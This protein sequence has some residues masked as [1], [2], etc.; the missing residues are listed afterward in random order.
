VQGL[1]D[2]DTRLK[3]LLGETVRENRRLKK[4]PTGSGSEDD[5]G[6]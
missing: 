3:P 1:R 6:G 5:A 4:R 2:E